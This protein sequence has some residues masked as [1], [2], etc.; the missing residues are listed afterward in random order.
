MITLQSAF[1][2]LV[3]LLLFGLVFN[4]LLTRSV[5]VKGS[6]TGVFSFRSMAHKRGREDEPLS[7]WFAILFYSVAM[8]LLI[9]L[10]MSGP[11]A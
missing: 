10:L 3:I 4:G 9:W 7:Y 5:W 11:V 2:V 1:V 6:R 8:L